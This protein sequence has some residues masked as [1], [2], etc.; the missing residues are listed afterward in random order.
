MV[1]V[2]W[3]LHER[4]KEAADASQEPHEKI[5]LA[6]GLRDGTATLQD[7]EKIL[8]EGENGAC[9]IEANTALEV[10]IQAAEIQVGRA[11]RGHG[12]VRDK[13]LGVDKAVGILVDLH[14]RADQLAIV[15]ARGEMHDL[16]VG[17]AWC[18]DAHVHAA[19]GGI[20]EQGE[21]GVV[22]HEVGGGD[23]E[24][25][26]CALD[27]LCIDLLTDRLLVHGAVR[28]GL[29]PAVLALGRFRLGGQELVDLLVRAAQKLPHLQKHDGKVPRAKTAQANGVVLPMA[30]ADLLVDVFVGEI[31][32]ARVGHASVDHGDLAV[33]AVV[34]ASADEGQD[35]VEDAALHAHGA[36]LAVVFRGKAQKA[37]EVIVDHAHVHALG[38]LLPQ[39][40][41][42][43]VPHD[44]LLDDEVFEED[45]ALC[46]AQ[47]PKQA[48]EHLAARWE[49]VG[50]G[51][52]VNG[53]LPGVLQIADQALMLGH[54]CAD[55][56]R[57]FFG[58][59]VLV[60][61]IALDLIQPLAVADLGGLEVQ[62]P[63]EDPAK[64]RKE[65]EQ[66]DQG[67]LEGLLVVPHQKVKGGDKTDEPQEG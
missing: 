7:P 28:V 39:D 52:A 2:L 34:V 33:V 10:E 8:L 12:I 11:D 45:I 42:N 54:L 16:L 56:R 64:E 1:C 43:G 66:E 65:Q 26:L 29:Y 53:K 44:A 4:G 55:L 5:G 47:V 63:V 49:V 48:L 9:P 30:V 40:L 61:Q 23:I 67:E 27:D 41:Q 50:L 14:A 32:A 20:L 36:K 3:L 62:D 35:L 60:A 22:H 46:G 6:I 19:F 51:R 24:I 37:A 58:F 15:G 38:D 59:S 57:A 21:H 17:G 18:D 13:G 25:A 31:D